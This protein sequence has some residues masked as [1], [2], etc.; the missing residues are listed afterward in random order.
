L[1]GLYF[2]ALLPPEKVQEE[3]NLIKRDF[4]RKY[5]SGHA[6][7]SRPRI[8]VHMAVKRKDTKRAE[9]SDWL[10][11][12]TAET[13]TFEIALDGFGAFPPKVIYMDVMKS[14]D[15][16]SFRQK[17]VHAMRTQLSLLNADYKNLPFKPHITV[18]FRDLRKNM[19]V[20]AWDHYRDQLFDA[21][22]TIDDV[23]LLKHNGLN[24][25]IYQRF[26]FTATT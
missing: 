4:H 23:V 22:F 2:V 3:I 1:E 14:D 8:G 16:W 24:W 12:V 7:R 18:A 26:P 10:E 21:T 15:L 5:A 9:L 19:F 6:L 20:K 25:E 17:T 13:S 11:R